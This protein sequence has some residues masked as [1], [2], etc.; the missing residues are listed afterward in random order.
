[1]ATLAPSSLGQP[2]PVSAAYIPNDKPPRTLVLCFD[3]T[4]DQ[5]DAD[6]S[7]QTALLMVNEPRSS[8]NLSTELERHPI[9]HVVEKRRQA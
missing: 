8:R 1:M 5:F 3:G 4:G 9:L 6:V 2:A 7:V